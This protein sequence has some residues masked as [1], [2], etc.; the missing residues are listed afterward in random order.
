MDKT[1]MG[2]PPDVAVRDFAHLGT[3][4]VWFVDHPSSLATRRSKSL[5]SDQHQAA[6]VATE[7]QQ[8]TEHIH[9]APWIPLRLGP[10]QKDTSVTPKPE[11]KGPSVNLIDVGIAPQ[12]KKPATSGWAQELM[13][14]MANFGQDTGNECSATGIS[15]ENSPPSPRTGVIETRR[16]SPPA[17]G[18]GKVPRRS[19]YIPTTT[20]TGYD[21]RLLVQ[22]RGLDQRP[23]SDGLTEGMACKDDRVIRISATE[24]ATKLQLER[25]RV[26]NRGRHRSDD[27][28]TRVSTTELL[29]GEPEAETGKRPPTTLTVAS[30]SAQ[31]TT[32]P[33]F[34][35]LASPPR[36]PPNVWPSLDIPPTRQQQQ[37]MSTAPADLCVEPEPAT[38]AMVPHGTGLG[39][40][41]DTMSYPVHLSTHS[42]G[43]L[44]VPAKTALI[45]AAQEPTI[46]T[47]SAPQLAATRERCER[48]Y[49]RV[50]RPHSANGPHNRE[51]FM[52]PA[53]GTY[54]SGANK[55][56]TTTASLT[57]TSIYQ[58]S[59][60]KHRSMPPPH[61]LLNPSSTNSSS[62][63]RQP[64]PSRRPKSP[65]QHPSSPRK[66]ATEAGRTAVMGT[67]YN[68]ATAGR[69]V[70]VVSHKRNKS[71]ACAA[72]KTK[73]TTTTTSSPTSTAGSVVSGSGGEGGDVDGRRSGEEG[74][75]D[76]VVRRIALRDP[77]AARS[78]TA[79]APEG[80][81]KGM[82]GLVV[83]VLLAYWDVVAPVFD[84]GSPVSARF[85]AGKCTWQDC[86]V[87]ALALVFVLGCFLAVVWGVK[88]AVLVIELGSAVVRGVGV[89]VGV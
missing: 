76:S 71:A 80:E 73:T 58:S 84:A 13:N 77:H 42:G 81:R 83:R 30:I 4:R 86:G 22:T 15:R 32:Q 48:L 60:P 55:E 6:K 34:D 53:T 1:P 2:S 51:A 5:D 27:R 75:N 79:A 9:R 57:Y 50:S 44:S 17:E 18:T 61:P 68:A 35:L 65:P 72:S 78:R 59:V 3:R 82:A 14:D 43:G 10:T 33:S 88:A 69:I 74:K 12:T 26:Q 37:R 40:V 38:T 31:Q 7:P 25:M 20:I 49:R 56:V 67:Q 36:L 11:V 46:P 23:R 39:P 47:T 29:N 64:T 24:A 87:Y 21:P 16:S 19:V 45:R 66:P 70:H 85:S 28:V 63:E 8:K 41:S 54:T 89:L 52:T 62:P